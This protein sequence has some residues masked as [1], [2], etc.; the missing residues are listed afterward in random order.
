MLEIISP[1][2]KSGISSAFYKY[3]YYIYVCVCVIIFNS[4]NP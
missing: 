4:S 1:I 3:R 2:K